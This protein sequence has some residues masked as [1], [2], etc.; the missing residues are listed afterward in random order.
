MSN[1]TL[2]TADRI[3]MLGGG[4]LVLLGIAIGQLNTLLNAPHIPVMEEGEVVATPVIAP[5]IRAYI[6]LLGLAVW[7]LYGVFKLATSPQNGTQSRSGVK[8]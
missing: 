2:T 6:I 1:T 5:E 7:L 8:S 4:G 3:A